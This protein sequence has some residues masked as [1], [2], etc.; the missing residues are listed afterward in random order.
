MKKRIAL[1]AVLVLVVGLLVSC[2]QPDN[3]FPGTMWKYVNET[4]DIA[5]QIEFSEDQ[6]SFYHSANRGLTWTYIPLTD[7]LEYRVKKDGLMQIK[8]LLSWADCPY[9]INGD[10]LTID[11]TDLSALLYGGNWTYTKTDIGYDEY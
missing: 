11:F 10:E 4:T 6:I 1:V 8:V 9:S 5:Q 3:P 7:V 2:A